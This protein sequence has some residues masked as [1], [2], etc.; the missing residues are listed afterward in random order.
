MNT[1]EKLMTTETRNRVLEAIRH[2]AEQAIARGGNVSPYTFED[3][4]PVIL[5]VCIPT[6]EC[7]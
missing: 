7:R 2:E 5:P 6:E 3:L 1:M 4:T